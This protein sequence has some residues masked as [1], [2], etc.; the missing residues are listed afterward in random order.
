MLPS[1]PFLINLYSNVVLVGRSTVA[2]HSGWDEMYEVRESAI[3][4]EV[5]PELNRLMDRAR[6][7]FSPYVVVPTSLK[8][9]ETVAAAIHIVDNVAA[10]LVLAVEAVVVESV[11]PT[12][13]SQYPYNEDKPLLRRLERIP[14]KPQ[15]RMPRL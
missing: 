9:L 11:V 10:V 13:K 7:M 12:P 8:V 1:L 6:N 3:A 4:D 2:L 15:Q 5:D 14:P